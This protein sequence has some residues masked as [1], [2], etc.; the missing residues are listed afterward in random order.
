MQFPQCELKCVSEIWRVIAERATS[1]SAYRGTSDWCSRIY[2]PSGGAFFQRLRQETAAQEVLS[3]AD[4]IQTGLGRC[5]HLSLAQGQGWQPD[6]LVLGKSLGGGLVPI[7]AVLGRADVLACLPAASE[8]ETFAASPFATAKVEVL[9]QLSQGEGSNRGERLEAGFREF[10]R[11]E[12]TNIGGLVA[13]WR[14]GAGCI[15]EFRNALAGDEAQL[16]VAWRTHVSDTW[17]T[18]PLQWAGPNANRV[19][20]SPDDG[21]SGI[22]GSLHSAATSVPQLNGNHSRTPSQVLQTA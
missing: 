20:A 22:R 3:I 16:V 5:G 10:A 17:R 9:N 2:I 7:S 18:D 13:L 8:S 1:L 15:V 6:L 21:S 12:L 11:I 14:A 19:V 4:E